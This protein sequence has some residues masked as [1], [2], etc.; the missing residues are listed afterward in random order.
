MEASLFSNSCSLLRA[1]WGRGGREGGERGR[2]EREEEGGERGGGGGGE[3]GGDIR[4][5]EHEFYNLCTYNYNF[6]C[7]IYSTLSRD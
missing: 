6:I 2:G 7:N 1:S 3:R 4:T 5:H